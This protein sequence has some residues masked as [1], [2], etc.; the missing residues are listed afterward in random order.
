MNAAG[1]RRQFLACCMLWFFLSGVEYAI[2][3]P[4]VHDYLDDIGAPANYIG[5]VIAS[6]S[7]G[8]MLSAPIYAKITDHYKRASYILKVGMLFSIGGS[9]MYFLFPYKNMIILARFVGGIGWG[10]EGALMGQIGRTFNQESKTAKFASVLMMRQFGVV[11]G[12]LCILFLDKL[13]FT[14]TIGAW[15]VEVT[16]YSSSG[17][18]LASAW[19]VAWLIMLFFY[20][21]PPAEDEMAMERTTSTSVTDS[22]LQIQETAQ[23]TKSSKKTYRYTRRTGLLHEPIIVASCCTFSTYILQSGMETLVTP[24]TDYYLGWGMRQNAIMYTLV[25]T[26][27]FTGYISMQFVSRKLDDR[28]TLLMGCCSLTFVLVTVIVVYPILEFRADWLYPVFGVALLIFCWFLPYVV[29]SAAA[30]LSKSASDDLQ[31]TVQAVR[32]TGEV[33]AQVASPP[34]VSNMMVLSEEF[35]LVFQLAF[36]AICSVLVVLSW[37]VLKPEDGIPYTEAKRSIVKSGGDNIELEN[38]LDLNEN[39][40]NLTRRLIDD[41]ALSH[42]SLPSAVMVSLTSMKQ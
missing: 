14:L 24:F 36:M 30:V 29:V 5:L 4:S 15:T 23:L 28:T 8:A 12:P 18:L 31:S 11:L 19:F 13:A 42:H 41:V 40:K 1:E 3:L 17:V 27:A 10:L 38:G 2:I 32:T 22:L 26:V 33:L 6:L 39:E 16:Q 35:T 37:K 20:V 21:D 7:L 34:W 9:C 25:G